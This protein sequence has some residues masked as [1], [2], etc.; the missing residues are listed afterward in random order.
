MK[1]GDLVK[2]LHPTDGV[3]YGAY[4]VIYQ[5]ERSNFDE[6]NIYKIVLVGSDR[7][8]MRMRDDLEVVSASR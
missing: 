3:P 8:A 5:I 6:F 1:I 4:A 2:V 7:S